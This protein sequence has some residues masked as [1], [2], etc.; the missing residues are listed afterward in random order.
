MIMKKVMIFV[1]SGAIIGTI[2]GG[3]FADK[4]V[5]GKTRR[6]NILP[7]VAA[8]ILGGAGACFGLLFFIFVGGAISIVLYL[9]TVILF[10]S[11][12]YNAA[13]F[14]RYGK[15]KPPVD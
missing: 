12:G 4:R 7:I 11:I 3:F 15:K 1:S 6:F 14:F 8:F 5:F 13:V 9:L 10:S 2:I